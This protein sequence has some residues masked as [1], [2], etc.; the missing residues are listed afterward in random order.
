MLCVFEQK[1]CWSALWSFT[2][3]IWLAETETYK[4]LR[5][6]NGLEEVLVEGRQTFPLYKPTLV[7]PQR[8]RADTARLVSSRAEFLVAIAIVVYAQFH[9]RTRQLPLRRVRRR[10]LTSRD[11]VQFRTGLTRL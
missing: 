6:E 8:I 10:H 2:R 3:P 11:L 1:E 5:V 9:S 7:A 4:T